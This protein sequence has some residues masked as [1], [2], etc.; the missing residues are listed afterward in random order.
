MIRAICFDFD[1]T[2]AHFTG[3]FDTLLGEGFARLG[4]D[5]EHRDTLLTEYER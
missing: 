5:D 1:G 3:D 2:L 4:L